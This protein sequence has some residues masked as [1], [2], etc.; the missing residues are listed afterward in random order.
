MK[1]KI[2]VYELSLIIKLNQDIAFDKT[3]DVVTKIIDDKIC[4]KL[5]KGY[6]TSKDF[7][8]YTFD[9]FIKFEE[10]GIY[11]KGKNYV[12]RIRTISKELC[13]IFF[14][15]EDFENE[16]LKVLKTTYRVLEKKMIEKLYTL[17][18]ALFKQTKG[19]RSDKAGYWLI[20]G[21]NIKEFQTFI[22][23]NAIRKYQFFNKLP[24]EF[25]EKQKEVKF[26][27]GIKFKK[28]GVRIEYKSKTLFTDKF[29]LKV[30]TD[31]LSQDIA[32]MLLGVG[33]LQNN[34][35]GLGFVVPRYYKRNKEEK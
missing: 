21:M 29:E 4:E 27:E 20:S 5:G 2:K 17:T 25:W 18:P 26:F 16:Y 11:K 22:N 31:E 15:L 35:R 9:N 1:D 32:Y 7:K 8:E 3:S 34:S 6:H 30:K 10:D 33:I 24:T 12:F 23:V 13:D 28:N 14:K 19:N